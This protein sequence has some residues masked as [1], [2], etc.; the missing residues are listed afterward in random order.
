[1]IFLH[2]AGL[3][4]LNVRYGVISGHVAM[5][6]FG[7]IVSVIFG[8]PASAATAGSA[9]TTASSAPSG[10]TAAKPATQAGVDVAAVLD[11]LAKQRKQKLNWR[12][13]IVDLMKLLTG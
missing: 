2:R 8:H 10:S 3:G 6:V 5:S 9:A 4:F 11:S 1:V 13:S 12:T 7:D